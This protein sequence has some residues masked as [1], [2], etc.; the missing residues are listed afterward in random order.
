M[1]QTKNMGLRL[2]GEKKSL[3]LPARPAKKKKTLQSQ[4]AVKGVFFVL[5]ALVFFVLFTLIPIVMAIVLAFAKYDG[6]G[7]I[8]WVGF[9]NFKNIFKLDEIFKKSFLN[10]A[11]Y[12][13]FAIPLSVVL[14]LVYALLINAKVPGKKVFR[15]IYYLPGLTSAVAAATVFRLVFNP[16]IGVVNSFLSVF[17]VKGP[18]WL[19]SSKTAMITIVM[20][21]MWQGIGGNMIIYAAALTG[22]PPELYEAARIDGAG[23][24]RTFFKITLPLL[25]PTTFFVLTMSIIGAFQLYDQVLIM[26]GGGPANSTVTPVYAIYERAFGSNSNMGYASAQAVL[27]F[28]VIGTISFL[29]QRLVKDRAY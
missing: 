4:L 29:T 28:V 24:A 9:S 13:L 5:P 17:G 3:L 6:I 8:A 27:L 11:W 18:Q 2:S 25:A 21:V 16:D 23:R 10:V 26:T 20:L 14:P 1:E 15:A 7:D 12:A 19:E 22:I